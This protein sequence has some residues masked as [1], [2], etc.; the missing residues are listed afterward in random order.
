M[1]R[2]APRPRPW[3]TRPRPARLAAVLAVLAPLVAVVATW[4]A[5]AGAATVSRVD[6]PTAW[7]VLVQKE[8]QDPQG[9]P[10]PEP[11]AEVPADFA[12]TISSGGDAASCAY[13]AG[14]TT[15][16]CT[17]PPGGFLVEAGASYTVTEMNL[18]VG[19]VDTEGI[20][21]FTT[22]GSDP[23]SQCRPQHGG[24]ATQCHH[25]VVNRAFAP[26]AGLTIEKRAVGGSGT[27]VFSIAC[28][29]PVTTDGTASASSSIE[30]QRTLTVAAGETG[31]TAVSGV[32]PG[33][34]CTVTETG[35]GGAT[36]TSVSGGTEVRDGAG[37]L[38]GVTTTVDGPATVGLTNTFPAVSDTTVAPPAAT[39]PTGPTTQ[40]L[41]ATITRGTLPATGASDDRLVAAGL[42]TLL[43]GLTCVCVARLR[44][45]LGST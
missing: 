3:L 6:G 18:P 35:T 1:I 14:S 5:T 40:V 37:V 39:A 34:T 24:I 41:G 19:Y 4:P 15:L 11:P 29:T 21:T 17:Y 45:A 43:L 32:T 10:L 28:E 25:M 8:W 42:G 27:F 7:P 36:L 44:R 23:G 38:H 12:I 16:A 31:S 33:S 13:P 30:E 22:G 9:T 20:G 2:P 26:A